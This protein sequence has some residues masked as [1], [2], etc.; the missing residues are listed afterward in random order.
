MF[1]FISFESLRWFF[2]TLFQLKSS[3]H[4][5]KLAETQISMLPW[6]L[7]PIRYLH[8]SSGCSHDYSYIHLT[9]SKQGLVHCHDLHHSGDWQPRGWDS[10]WSQPPWADQA[11]VDSN[12]WCFQTQWWRGRQSA[13]YLKVLWCN[14]SFWNNMFG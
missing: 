9:G 8:S 11:E 7:Q 5:N 2:R 1:Y 6:C 3:S 13:I 14:F 12:Q 10:A 4:K